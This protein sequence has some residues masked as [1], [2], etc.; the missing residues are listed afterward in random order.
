M[1]PSRPALARVL[2]DHFLIWEPRDIV[3]GDFFWF[4]RTNRGFYLAVGDCTG[5]GVPGA[6]MT[7]IACGLIDRHLRVLEEP[8]PAE[9]LGSLHRELQKLLGQDEAVGET[10]DGLEAGVCFVD[11]AA[12]RL[13]YAGARFPLWRARGGA[14]D[15]TKGDRAGLGYRRFPPDTA[16]GEVVLEVEAGDA[17]YLATDGIIDQVGGA[18]RRAFGKK[19]LVEVLAAN[20]ARPMAAQ[21]RAIT[22]TL[23]AYQGAEARRDDVTVLGFVPVGP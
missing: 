10:D 1:L 3:G 21:G 9:L 20:S 2:P 19:R 12:R 15:E 8:S 7:L 11:E 6:F 4:H 5:H 17:F 22:E 18:R 16:W 23:A 13:A 14:I